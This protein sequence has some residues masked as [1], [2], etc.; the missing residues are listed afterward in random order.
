M[1]GNRP[2]L[3]QDVTVFVETYWVILMFGAIA[4]ALALSPLRR[5]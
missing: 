2:K 5:R 4:V 3:V 1:T